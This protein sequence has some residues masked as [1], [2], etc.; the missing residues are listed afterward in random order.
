LFCIYGIYAASTEGISKAW[1]SDLIPSHLR[2]TAI[3][4]V[5]TFSSFGVMLGSM[6]TGILWDSFGYNVP[7]L[8]SS[9]VS[10]MLG[11]ILIFLK[12]NRLIR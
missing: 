3:G 7:F 5:T 12:K 10:L 4:L 2:G 11:I 9:I 6:L 8:I 1:I